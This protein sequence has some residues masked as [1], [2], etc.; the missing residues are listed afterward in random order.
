MPEA[1]VKNAYPRAREI[2]A[3]LGYANPSELHRA[4]RAWT[5][6]TTGQFRRS[7]ARR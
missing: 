7:E 4:F 6:M 5:G 2:A 1:S 3:R